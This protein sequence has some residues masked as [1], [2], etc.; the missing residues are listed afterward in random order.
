MV[1]DVVA[2]LPLLI[3]VFVAEEES[4]L[5]LCEL[6]RQENYVRHASQS[7]SSIFCN[8]QFILVSLSLSLSLLSLSLSSLED[9]QEKSRISR[10]DT[11]HNFSLH[12]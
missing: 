1:A 10:R 5:T 8:I 3:L 12:I 4:H 9:K 6:C 2:S 7:S 11:F